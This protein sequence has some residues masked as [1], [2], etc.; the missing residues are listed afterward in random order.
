MPNF[1]DREDTDIFRIVDTPQDAVRL[2]K[3]G[4]KKPWWQPLDANLAKAAANGK[5]PKGPMAGGSKSADTGEGTRYGKRPRRSE[6]S[7]PSGRADKP[8]Q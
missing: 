7:L 3:A 1:I 6:R 4:V 2:V 8:T 5:S